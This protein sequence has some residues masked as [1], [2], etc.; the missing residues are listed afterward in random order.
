MQLWLVAIPD[1]VGSRVALW[2]LVTLNVQPDMH[3]ANSRDKCF[4]ST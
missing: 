4:G 2:V 3:E 1:V